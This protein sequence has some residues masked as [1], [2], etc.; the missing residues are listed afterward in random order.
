MEPI[1]TV[2]SDAITPKEVHFDFVL[3]TPLRKY[4]RYAMKL[5]ANAKPYKGFQT[6]GKNNG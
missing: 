1:T 2:E 4:A 5:V 6:R 3:D